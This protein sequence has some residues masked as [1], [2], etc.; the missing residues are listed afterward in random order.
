M[1]GGGS[2]RIA[3]TARATSTDETGEVLAVPIGS[4][5]SSASRTFAAA[6]SRKKPSRKT[7]GRTV[8]TGRPDHESACSASQCSLCCGLSVVSVILIVARGKI[9]E[10]ALHDL[11]A[12]PAQGL[13]ALILPPDEGAHLV[14]LGEQHCGE[15]AADSA[16]GAGRS[17]HEDRAVVFG[18]H[19]RDA[20]LKLR[21]EGL[22]AFGGS[23]DR[24]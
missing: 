8:T 4:A 7:V 17:G 15:V 13:G 19:H 20:G 14:A 24:A 11:S 21:S 18:L 23:S 1:C 2:S 10:V 16:D 5:S 3:A 9:R 22:A 12:E 6:K